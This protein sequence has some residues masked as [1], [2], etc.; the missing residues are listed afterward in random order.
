MLADL[1]YLKPL[2]CT[3]V[4]ASTKATFWR[5]KNLE[6]V[7][8]KLR[9]DRSTLKPVSVTAIECLQN[10]NSSC[11]YTVFLQQDK[12]VTLASKKNYLRK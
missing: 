9:N 11:Y 12:L 5:A 8:S 7:T 3:K 4:K 1:H 2:T 6:N 10:S